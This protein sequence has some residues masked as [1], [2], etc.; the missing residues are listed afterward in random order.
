M[1]MS[2]SRTADNII[3]FGQAKCWNLVSKNG[4]F[5]Q[6]MHGNYLIWGGGSWGLKWEKKSCVLYIN[7]KSKFVFLVINTVIDN[8][9]NVWITCSP[10]SRVCFNS[11]Q[12]IFINSV[13]S[14]M[15]LAAMHTTNLS[16]GGNLTIQGGPEAVLPILGASTLFLPWTTYTYT[17]FM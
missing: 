7:P 8:L 17:H 15:M 2:I 5:P 10:G 4:I 9:L 1:W 16:I 6:I 11:Q 13:L 12:Q 3:Y 14:S